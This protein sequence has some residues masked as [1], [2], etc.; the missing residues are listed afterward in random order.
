MS[1]W[2]WRALRAEVGD[3]TEFGWLHG[4]ALEHVATDR[5]QRIGGLDGALTA[6][7][8]QRP[9]V[10]EK[11]EWVGVNIGF[12]VGHVYYSSFSKTSVFTL[13][14]MCERVLKIHK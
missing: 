10:L 5:G 1:I 9:N 14:R 6:L 13:L 7:T 8:Q 4:S 2:H 12:H 3:S 11:S